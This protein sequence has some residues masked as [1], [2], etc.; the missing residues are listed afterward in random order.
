M[1]NDVKSDK[2]MQFNDA[3]K[4]AVEVLAQ[5]FQELK[6]FQGSEEA[7]HQ[8]ASALAKQAE[9]NLPNKYKY[10][11]TYIWVLQKHVLRQR[12]CGNQRSLWKKHELGIAQAKMQKLRKVF[13]CK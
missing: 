13:S 1:I 7:H 8:Q 6:K 2:L 10:L 11:A 9:E 5:A 4:K 12:Q 3:Q